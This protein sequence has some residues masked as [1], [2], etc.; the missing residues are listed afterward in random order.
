MVKVS[1]EI[2]AG[3][4]TYFGAQHPG[5]LVVTED[6]EEGETVREM[7]NRLAARHEKFSQVIFDPKSQRLTDSVSLVFNGR[8]IELLNGLDTPMKDGDAILFLPA[9][10]GG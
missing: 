5:R 2:M 3:L 10:A 8:L 7:L 9:Y 1:L 4:A 6:V